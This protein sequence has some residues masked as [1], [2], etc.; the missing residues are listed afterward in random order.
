MRVGLQAAVVYVL[1]SA[2]ERQDSVGRLSFLWCLRQSRLRNM[3]DRG[4][5]DFRVI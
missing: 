1:R 2:W 3:L 4:S 5:F